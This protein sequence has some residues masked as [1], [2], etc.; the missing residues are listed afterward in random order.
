MAFVAKQ[1]TTSLVV[2]CASCGAKFKIRPVGRLISRAGKSVVREPSSPGRYV[3]NMY[4]AIDN[5]RAKPELRQR[6]ATF[7][8]PAQW[9]RRHTIH[10][11][12][13]S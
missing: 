7:H 8:A 3:D 2:R 5:A 10:N 6:E 4:L 1:K 11:H 12:S 13:V 9:G